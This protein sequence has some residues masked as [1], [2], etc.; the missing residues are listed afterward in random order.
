MLYAIKSIH[1]YLGD[2][3]GKPMLYDNIKDASQAAKD[4]A[5][6]IRF[7]MSDYNN[8]PYELDIITECFG[9]DPDLKVPRIIINKLDNLGRKCS[10]DQVTVVNGQTALRDIKNYEDIYHEAQIAFDKL[11]KYVAGSK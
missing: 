1:H 6:G 2:G 5:E 7:V 9:G 11:K 10:M 4:Y 3:H 8:K